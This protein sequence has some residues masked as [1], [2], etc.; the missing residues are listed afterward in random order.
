VEE[1]NKIMERR[2]TKL[3]CGNREDWDDRVL[4]VLWVYM[5]TRKKIHRYTPFQLVYGKEV[6]I[7]TKFITPSLYI[8]RATH[9]TDDESV[10]QR[11]ADLQELEEAR[12]LAYFHQTIEKARQKSYNDRNINNKIFMEGDKLLL[13]DNRYQ[14]HPGKLCMHW[15]G[16]F[17]V[18][19][20]RQCGAIRLAELDGILRPKWVNGACLKPYIYHY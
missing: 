5:T 15:L 9:I 2:L 7:P 1:F 11:I 4:A 20:M 3:C 10:A 14:K 8:A 16:P 13:Y 19:E 18:A 17:I 6:G 12:F